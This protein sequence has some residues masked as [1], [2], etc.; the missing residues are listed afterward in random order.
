[1]GANHLGINI[2]RT[3]GVALAASPE[4]IFAFLAIVDTSDAGK[5]LI[6]GA[7]RDGDGRVS[8]EDGF[9]CSEWGNTYRMTPQLLQSDQQ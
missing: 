1:M 4:S 8:N 2:G 6:V 5:A 9:G 7:S 3:P